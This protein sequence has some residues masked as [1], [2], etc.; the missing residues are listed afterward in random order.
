MQI[1]WTFSDSETHII[2]LYQ[3]AGNW[4]KYYTVSLPIENCSR[5]LTIILLSIF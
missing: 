3:L 2:G 1:L 4:W 5:T